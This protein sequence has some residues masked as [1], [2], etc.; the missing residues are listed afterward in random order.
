[1]KI[2]SVCSKLNFN[3][4]E[5]KEKV[6]WF[7]AGTIKLSENGQLYLRMFHQPQVEFVCFEQQFDSTEQ[8]LPVIDADK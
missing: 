8:P 2:F 7:R 6:K 5:G 4:R 3:D 1:M